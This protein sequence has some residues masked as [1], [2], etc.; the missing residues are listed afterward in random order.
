M[1]CTRYLLYLQRDIIKSMA[2][3]N[4]LGKW[5]EDAVA[6]YL[7]RKG[8]TILERDWHS[9]HRD[10]DIIAQDGNTIVFVE[11][12]TRR[13]RLFTDP[14]QAVDYRKIRNL[15]YAMNHYV[16]FKHLNNDLRFD[17]ITVV[18]TG[19]GKPEIIHMEDVRLF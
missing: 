13:N 18:G 9:G 2:A 11:V 8:L 15:S 10:I 4:E 1:F 3:H 12:K 14:E 7:Q 17:I 6:E 16:K 5:G 19:E